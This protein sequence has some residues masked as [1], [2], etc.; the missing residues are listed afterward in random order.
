[1]KVV[2]LA[3][4]FG[5]RIADHSNLPKPMI[6]I[7]GKPIISH[8]LE[9]FISQGFTDFLIAVGYKGHIIKKYFK[10][11]FIEYNIK[12]VDTGLKTLT[13]NRLKKLKNYLNEDNFMLTYGDGLCNINIKK[14]LKFHRSHKKLVTVTAVH[15]PA[16]FGELLLKRTNVISFD[17]KPQLQKGWINGGF[18]IFK[19]EF[20][21]LI[22]KKQVMLEREPLKIAVK[23]K[24]FMAFKHKFFWHCMDNRRDHSNLEKLCK[25][26]KLPWLKF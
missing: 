23:K 10:Q 2:I 13:G 21:D 14:L 19:K 6:S 20:L 15:P 1:M 24:Q 18:F 26:K 25:L 7:N 12:V 11:N 3:G 9:I 16:R 22:P 5:T 4:G 17:E 8:I